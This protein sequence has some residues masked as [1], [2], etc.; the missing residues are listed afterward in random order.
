MYSIFNIIIKHEKKKYNSLI[1]ISLMTEIN[2][3]Y[4]KFDDT[5]NS[6]F[7]TQLVRINK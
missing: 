7:V 1:I 2:R 3:K 5:G 6:K 4:I